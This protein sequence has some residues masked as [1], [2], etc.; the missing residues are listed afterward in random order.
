MTDI[1]QGIETHRFNAQVI[2]IIRREKAKPSPRIIPY[3]K[4]GDNG[5]VKITPSDD[6]S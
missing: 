4:L 5:A 6:M 1:D 3:P 2:K